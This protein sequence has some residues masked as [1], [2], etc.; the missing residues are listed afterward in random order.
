MKFF[1]SD[2]HQIWVHKKVL[3]CVYDIHEKAFQAKKKNLEKF[4]QSITGMLQV[5]FVDDLMEKQVEQ[6]TEERIGK[7]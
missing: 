1:F 7:E 4:A 3:A 6:C 2:S 5:L